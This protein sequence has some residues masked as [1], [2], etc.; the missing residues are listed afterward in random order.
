[1]RQD[2]EGGIQ[3][4]EAQGRALKEAAF[5]ELNHMQDDPY[6]ITALGIML[7][8]GEGIQKNLAEAARLYKIAADMGYAPAQYTYSVCLISGQG[9]PKNA[10]AARSYW[11]LAYNQ[12]YGPALKG[13][14][15]P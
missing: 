3:Q 11:Q 1:M 12:G 5:Q 15:Q 4:D 8:R 7:F 10:F 13:M 9:V 6:A 14:P 2:G